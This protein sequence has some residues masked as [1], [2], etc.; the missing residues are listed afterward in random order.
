ML[1]LDDVDF[2]G[3]GLVR[4]E[5]VLAT[6]AGDLFASDFRGGVSHIRPDGSQTLYLGETADLPE[7]PRPNGIA[8][9][10][11]GSFLFANLGAELGGIWR[12]DRSGQVRPVLTEVDGVALPPSN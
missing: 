7:G 1:S 11:D 9:E 2:V 5:C 4:P 3:S 10:R 6:R 8:L 12:L